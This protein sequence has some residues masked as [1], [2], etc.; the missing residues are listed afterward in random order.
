MGREAG[1]AIVALGY[2]GV[3]SDRL[4]DWSDFAGHLLG[5]QKI[6]RGG[7]AL[8][9]RM[10]DRLQRLLVS[11]EPGETLAFLGFEVSSQDTLDHYAARLDA[12]GV[13]VEQGG[14]ALADRRFVGDLIWFHD[15]AGNRVELF[16]A[17][18]IA[19]DPFVSGRPIDGFVTGPLGMGH[20][21]LHVKDIDV[22]MPFY[23][24]LLDFSVSDYGLQPYGLYFFHLNQRHHS[25]AMVGSGQEGFHHFM[26]EFRNL[27]D[28]GQGYDLA[29]QQDGRIAYTLGRHTNDY[30]TSYYANS[31]SGFFVEN[32]WGGRLIDPAT[33]TPHETHDGPSFWGHERLHLTEEGGRRRLREMRLDAAARGRRSPPVIDCPW[34]YG[35]FAMQG[36]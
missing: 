21:V 22:M 20:A 19:S 9:F 33:W 23:R 3:R 26:V 30:M 18:M 29:G 7:K 10:D 2:L 35:Q 17:P 15:P 16:H 32:G 36:R 31:P 1:G 5:M 6:D 4:D 27:D 11:D 14:R 34:L 28:L 13:R 24:D 8:A 25:F 12:A